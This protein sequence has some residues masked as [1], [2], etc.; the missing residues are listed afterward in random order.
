[1]AGLISR[2]GCISL[3]LLAIGL[4]VGTLFFIQA[5]FLFILPK[6]SDRLYVEPTSAAPALRLPTAPPPTI[7]HVPLAPPIEKFTAKEPIRGFNDCTRYG[8][9]GI[10]WSIAQEP[11]ANVQVV[12]WEK[13]TRL[14]AME[15]TDSSGIYQIML[16]GSANVPQFW[17]QIYQA[18]QPVSNPLLLDI[19]SDC[20]QGYQVYQIDWQAIR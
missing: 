19:H 6:P 1:M 5:Y 2:T 16:S 7:T 11:L 12:I 10:V 13:E 18:D 9:R 14:V 17:V 4:L 20:S 3:L 15:T 8:F